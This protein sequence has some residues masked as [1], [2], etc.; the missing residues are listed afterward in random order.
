MAQRGFA[1]VL[2][3]LVLLAAWRESSALPRL[4]R[5]AVGLAVLA[6]AQVALGASVIWT[7]GRDIADGVTPVVAPVPAS[8]HVVTGAALLVGTWLLVL[9]T[10]PA[11]WAPAWTPAWAPAWAGPQGAA[12]AA[13]VAGAAGAAGAGAVTGVRLETAPAPGRAT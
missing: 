5:H 8:L 13:G 4:R 2:V 1:L 10:H 11:R 3:A 9:R 6:L 7:A 12:G